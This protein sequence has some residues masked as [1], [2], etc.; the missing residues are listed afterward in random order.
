MGDLNDHVVEGTR[1]ARLFLKP[2]T[3]F[4]DMVGVVSAPKGTSRQEFTQSWAPHGDGEHRRSDPWKLVLSCAVP[5]TL[6]RNRHNLV[7]V[8]R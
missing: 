5:P 8:H 1:G 4:V 7:K 6:W 2:K 3:S